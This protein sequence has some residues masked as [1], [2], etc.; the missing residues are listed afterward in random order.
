[1]RKV[2][3]TLT[4]RGNYGKMLS[5]MRAIRARSDLELQLIVGGG[6]LSEA[7]GNFV[8]VVESDGFRIDRKIDYLDGLSG[9]LSTMT[10]SAGRAVEL[11]GNSFAE[12]APDVVVVI[13]DRYEALSIAMAATCRTIPIA[14]LEGGESSGSIDDR[15]RH[16]ITMLAQIH[17]PASRRAAERIVSMGENPGLVYTVGSPSFDII[18]ALNIEDL[19]PLDAFQ[20]AKGVGATLDHRAPFLLV[21]QHPV[22]GEHDSAEAQIAETVAAVGEIGLPVMWVQPNMDAGSDGVRNALLRLSQG[23]ASAPIRFYTALPLQIYARAMKACCCMLG[24]TSS[25]IREAAFIGVPVVNVGSRQRGRERGRNVIDVDYRRAEMVAAIRKQIAHGPYASDP[26]YGN[27]RSG[28]QIA[29][30]LATASLSL[31]K[32]VAEP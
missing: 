9:D 15:I 8:P 30:I 3:I 6:I 1:M 25:G 10:R 20:A 17:L 24:N 12:L 2:A 29:E 14:H 4:T 19:A 18:S 22:V 7:Y 21:S 16:A 5:T 31:D 28:E 11:F 26:I 23:G 27:G 13:A 32:S